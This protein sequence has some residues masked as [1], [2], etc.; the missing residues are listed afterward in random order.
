VVRRVIFF[1]RVRLVS[2]VTGY[3]SLRGNI[4]CCPRK[5]NVTHNLFCIN[6]HNY[7]SLEL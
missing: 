7:R 4:L 3:A 5:E 1:P 2:N 6:L